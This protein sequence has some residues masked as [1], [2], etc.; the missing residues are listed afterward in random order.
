MLSKAR[1]FSNFLCKK[2]ERS[3]NGEGAN[4]SIC[5]AKAEKTPKVSIKNLK[6]FEGGPLRL[7]YP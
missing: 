2:Q 6:K 5:H 1:Q 3:K 7:R 4:F